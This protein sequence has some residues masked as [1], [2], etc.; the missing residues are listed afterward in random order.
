[1][2]YIIFHILY[3]CSND[4]FFSYLQYGFYKIEL[5]CKVGCDMGE[6]LHSEDSSCGASPPHPMDP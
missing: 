1:M 4:C 6:G 5:R 3:F 2:K